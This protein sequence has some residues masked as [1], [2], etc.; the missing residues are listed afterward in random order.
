LKT[1]DL[2]VKYARDMI[3]LLCLVALWKPLGPFSC[4]E[5]A[6]Q[7][8]VSPCWY[9]QSHIGPSFK[10]FWNDTLADL[11]RQKLTCWIGE[12]RKGV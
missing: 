10:E 6:Q 7:L 4:C 9:L 11:Q 2:A 1:V 5:N 12:K 8:L 3:S